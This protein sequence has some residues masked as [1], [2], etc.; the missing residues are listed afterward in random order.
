MSGESQPVVAAEMPREGTDAGAEPVLSVENL[1]VSLLTHGGP[2]EVVSDISFSI[3]A[4]KTMCLVGESGCGKSVSAMA[5]LGLLKPRQF[6]IRARAIRLE[7]LDLTEPSGRNLALVRGRRVGMI[8]QE[9]MTSLNPTMAVG[10]QI[11]EVLR[12][13]LRL[14]RPAARQRAIELL[15]RVRIPRAR[16]RVDDYPFAFSGGMRQRVMIAIAIAC[17]PSLLIADEPTTALDVTVQS[18]IFDL[19]RELQRDSGMAMLLITHDLGV[20]AEVAE[21]VAVMYAGRIVE[22]APT[23]ALFDAPQ[24]P[25]TIGLFG[26]TPEAATGRRLTPIPGRVPLPV[27]RQPAGI[28][29]VALLRH[30]QVGARRRCRARQGVGR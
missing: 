16:Q 4:G 7:G 1:T 20:V 27:E 24:H 9:P 15:E 2:V 3:P 13:H 11:T 6:R 10:E 5:V 8:F 18:Q 28:A 23:A 14:S 30:R 26:S 29:R 19:L 21:E 22:Q 17:S 25:Y 12:H